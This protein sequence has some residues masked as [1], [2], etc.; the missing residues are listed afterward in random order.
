MHQY[1][2]DALPL[3]NSKTY[4]HPV[5]PY[6]TWGLLWDSQIKKKESLGLKFFTGQVSRILKLRQEEEIPI[7]NFCK[8]PVSQLSK[9]KQ[10]KKVLRLKIQQGGK[11]L[12]FTE[13]DNIV[14]NFQDSSNSSIW[15]ELKFVRLT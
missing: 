13:K 4:S 2:C 7:E 10:Q 6:I 3:D 5:L 11:G 12:Q 9:F 8:L 15:D 1:T 14:T